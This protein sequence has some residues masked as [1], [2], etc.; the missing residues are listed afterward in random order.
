MAKLL[1]WGVLLV[2]LIRALMRLA[3]A[4]TPA[5]F[6]AVF[7]DLTQPINFNTKGQPLRAVFVRR[8]PTGEVWTPDLHARYPGRDWMLT[9]IL[10]LSGSERA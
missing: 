8:R 10:W 4:F 7:A 6:A 1:I 2:I 5:D 9:R 3:R